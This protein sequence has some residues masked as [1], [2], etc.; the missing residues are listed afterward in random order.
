MA[1]NRLQA[2]AG[3]GDGLA[4]RVGRSRTVPEPESWAALGLSS[5]AAAL[6]DE[7]VRG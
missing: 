4:R 3:D 2:T 5:L 1:N 7:G 6:E